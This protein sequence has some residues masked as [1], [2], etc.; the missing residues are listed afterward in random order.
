MIVLPPTSR[1]LLNVADVVVNVPLAS[2]GGDAQLHRTG[3]A[4]H[5]GQG[6]T[7]GDVQQRVIALAVVVLPEFPIRLQ[8]GLVEVEHLH[9]HRAQ[10]LLEAAPNVAEKLTERLGTVVQVDEDQAILLLRHGR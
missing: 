8:D 1:M 10:C 5:P 4:E 7:V 9:R 3:F 6:L 2:V